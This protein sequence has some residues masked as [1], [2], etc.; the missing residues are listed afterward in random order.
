MVAVGRGVLKRE[1]F[2]KPMVSRKMPRG[3]DH[4]EKF[5]RRQRPAVGAGRKG[6]GFS[7]LAEREKGVAKGSEKFAFAVGILEGNRKGPSR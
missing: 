4:S 3:S 5:G 2:P 6:T 1:F 7:G